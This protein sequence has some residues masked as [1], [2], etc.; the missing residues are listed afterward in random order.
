MLT[1]AAHSPTSAAALLSAVRSHHDALHRQL[2]HYHSEALR[3]FHDT[4]YFGQLAIGTPP[5]QFGVVFDTGSANL[6]VPGLACRTDGCLRHS[7]FNG[8]ASTTFGANGERLYIRFGTG[9]VSGRLS[10]DTVALHEL[11]VQKQ[12]FLEVSD[13]R[14]FPFGEYPFSG[15]VGLALPALAADG[16]TPLFDSIM[17]Q[18]LLRRNIFA[19]HLAPLGDPRGSSLVFG[20][21]DAT[22]IRGSIAWVPRAPSSVYWE[23]SMTDIFLDGAP[24]NACRGSG[25]GGSITHRDSPSARCRV[26]IDTGTSLFTGPAAEIRALTRR[27]QTAHERGGGARGRCSLDALPMLSFAVGPHVF[28]FT[29]ADYVLHSAAL[30]ADGKLKAE[31]VS[32]AGDAPL[33]EDVPL[34]DGSASTAG[35]LACPCAFAFM[36]L[37]VPPPRGP[38]WIFGDVFMRKYHPIFDRDAERVGFALS[39]HADV[40]AGRL[41]IGIADEAP[42]ARINQS[43]EWLATRAVDG[44]AHSR[45]GVPPAMLRRWRRHAIRE[46]VSRRR[47]QWRLAPTPF[48]AQEQDGLSY[49]RPG[50]AAA[51]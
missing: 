39:A 10:H 50:V 38:L 36:A 42:A 11:V 48:V 7:R 44:E 20:D 2:P 37:E 23:V 17:A 15:I 4:Q 9:E 31:D 24:L 19:F 1:S 16:A 40:P 26:A 43:T 29:P 41:H 22:R 25:G 8:S 28:A 18:R 12:A 13:V 35:G 47:G 21:V 30:D 34:A 5:Q 45:P 33:A 46:Q 32:L 27:L 3:N 6:W 49:L 14:A 51:R